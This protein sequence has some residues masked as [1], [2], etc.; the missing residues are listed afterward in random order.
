MVFENVYDVISAE[1]RRAYCDSLP[2]QRRLMREIGAQ[3][4]L[5]L[6]KLGKAIRL[7]CLVNAK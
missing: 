7:A 4:G 5:T 6:R 3:K 1:S 2:E